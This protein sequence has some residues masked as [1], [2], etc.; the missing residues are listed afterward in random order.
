[1]S[2]I[3]SSIHGYRA[4]LAQRTRS[5][6]AF[7]SF[8]TSTRPQH[9]LP[10]PLHSGFRWSYLWYAS[11]LAL[12]ISTGLGAR[13]FAGPLGLPLPGSREDEIILD[14]LST[15]IDNLEIV[16][17]LR[18]QSYNLSSDTSLRSG[19][20]LGS[21][22]GSSARGG[23]SR[24]ISAYKDWLELDMDLSNDKEGT[25]GIL[26][27]MSG[28]RGLGV[29][30]AFWNANAQE[31]V[32][33]V[34]IGGGLSGWPG[35]V[36]GGAI[37]TIFE[38][39]MARM[40]KGPEGH[41]V[42]ASHRPNT[43]AMAYAKP[44]YSLDFYILRASFQESENPDAETPLPDPEAEPTRSRL[45]WLSPSKDLTKKNSSGEQPARV[46]V[47]T[48]ENVRGDFSADGENGHHMD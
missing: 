1:M 48:L 45:S 14:S 3:C 2:R 44:T 32:A 46:I 35:V 18:S 34:W 27:V 13:Y 47:G 39:V 4:T 42:E 23:G 15:D 19:P 31:M 17:S 43:L 12:G 28:T 24:K 5:H 40:V 26:G 6:P 37:A 7:R 25:N 16:Q 29:Q 11:I 30:R 33:V 21:D 9:I 38:E 8:R 22:S 36:H 10:Q 41:V 20:G